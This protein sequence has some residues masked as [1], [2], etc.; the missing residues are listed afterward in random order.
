MIYIKNF[1][2]SGMRVILKSLEKPS[3]NNDFLATS[4]DNR[5]KM[6]D[7]TYFL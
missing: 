7:I 6:C 2:M 4:K 5:K 3:G 1:L